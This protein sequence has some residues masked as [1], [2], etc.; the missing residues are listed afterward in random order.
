MPTQRNARFVRIGGHGSVDVAPFIAQHR[1]ERLGRQSAAWHGEGCFGNIVVAE[2]GSH[3]DEL[4]LGRDFG[5]FVVFCIFHSVNSIAHLK[6]EAKNIVWP[7]GLAG[8]GVAGP[9]SGVGVG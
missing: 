1:G 6:V 5:L 4:R 2:L 3:T 7:A 9:P 8:G